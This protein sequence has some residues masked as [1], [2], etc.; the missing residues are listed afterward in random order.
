MRLS[1]GVATAEQLS[2]HEADNVDKIVILLL[3]LEEE[4]VTS[5]LDHFSEDEIN[6]IKD[7]A[8]RLGPIT[9][10]QLKSVVDEFE[11][12]LHSNENR[13][14]DPKEVSQLLESAAGPAVDPE[15]DA[16]R[17]AATWNEVVQAE[18][19]IMFDCLENE[20]PQASAYVLSRLDPQ[21]ASGLLLRFEPAQKSEIVRRMISL[22]PV[23]S[24]IADLVGRAIITRLSLADPDD[25][26]SA[27]R[28]AVANIIN[29][30][31]ADQR[32]DLL[33]QLSE[34]LPAEVTKLKSLLFS[35][36]DIPKLDETS[37]KL[38]FDLVPSDL[39]IPA[40]QGCDADF[41][42]MIL[43]TLGARARRMVEAELSTSREVPEDATKQARVSIASTALSLAQDEKITLPSSGE[44]E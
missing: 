11:T 23:D 10:A 28:Q 41:V 34:S 37:R 4:R 26:P 3:A 24:Q 9:P 25:G 42:E 1:T 18:T 43:S 36:E 22:K 6:V 7:A 13:S 8:D 38:L 39:I 14:H 32:E 2:L 15:A 27:N 29:R 30:M 44:D 16:A 5:L 35:F 12:E 40:V 19:D 21:T 20:H 31:D 17:L 33:T